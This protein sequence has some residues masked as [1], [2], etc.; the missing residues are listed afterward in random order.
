MSGH[1]RLR[2]LW[3]TQILTYVFARV[4][5][6]VVDM[7]SPRFAERIGRLIGRLMYV[8][9][10][11]HRPIAVKNLAGAQG[12]PSDLDKVCRLVRRV[13][14]HFG[15]CIVENLMLPRLIHG[16][17]LT[18][19]TKLEGFEIV[20]RALKRGHG[21][22][23]VIAHL[24]NWEWAGLAVSMA[25]YPLNSVA[26]PIENPYLDRYVHRFRTLTGQRIIPK[27]NA[28]RAMGEVLRRNEMLVILADQDARHGGLLVPFFGRLAS[29]VR[30]PALMALRYGA[31]VIPVNIWRDRDGKHRVRMTEPL[32][33]DG[34]ASMEEAV[35]ALTS[36]MNHR[37]EQFVRE[38]P[39]QWMW[40]HARWKT[41][42]RAVRTQQAAMER[43][44]SD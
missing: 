33:I 32:E 44:S 18:Q 9:D 27:D 42:N 17:R 4:V 24:G 23:I 39:T 2:R 11:K 15:V 6:A 5:I 36:A 38:H 22:I 34:H 31:P 20:E 7:F 14:E 40:L 1:F 3:P 21:A 28:L 35:Q 41:G 16:R 13:Y 37:L 19:R 30:S 12:M 26:R 43:A 29:T 25:G 10:V 8:M